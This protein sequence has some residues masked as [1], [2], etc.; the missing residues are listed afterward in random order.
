MLHAS[1]NIKKEKKLTKQTINLRGNWYTKSSESL[2]FDILRKR[3][4]WKARF[5][6]VVPCLRFY[7]RWI[8]IERL[9]NSNFFICPKDQLF[10]WMLNVS[11]EWLI[12]I[13]TIIRYFFKVWNVRLVKKPLKMAPHFQLFLH[14]TWLTKAKNDPSSGFLP[15][16][17]TFAKKNTLKEH[18]TK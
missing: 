7:V 5:L 17:A 6:R 11:V 8:F 15:F 3:W 4:P 16:L 14:D 18:V 12:S 10:Y 1:I 13:C 2:P 9:T